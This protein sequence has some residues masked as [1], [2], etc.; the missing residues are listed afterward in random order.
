MA[1]IMIRFRRQLFSGLFALIVATVAALWLH[2]KFG[3]LPN[4]AFLT[5]WALLA[6]MFVLTIYNARKKLPFLPLGKSE[7]WLQIHIYLGFFTTL[8]FLIHLNFRLPRGWFEIMLAWLFVLVSGSGVVGLFFS[9]VLPRRL[10][11][12]GG[13]AIYEKIPAL[14][15]AL[16]TEAEKLALGADAKS[17]VIAEFYA[18]RLA[19]FFAG[20]KY[21]WLHLSESRR[22]LNAL[23]AGVEDLRRTGSDAERVTLEKLAVLIRQKDG[24]DYHRALQLTLKSWLFIHIPLTYGLLIF[25][26]LHIVLVFGFSGGAR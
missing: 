18:R 21:S 22:P 25:T 17:P 24:L 23:L 16:K 19:G 4:Y 11:T 26:A 8:L 7:T 12:R 9:R 10:A 20:P 3:A 5:G 15:H 2:R 1:E 14:R 6:G 13:E